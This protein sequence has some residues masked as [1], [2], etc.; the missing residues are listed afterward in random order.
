MSH[1]SVLLLALLL[2]ALAACSEEP[3]PASHPAAQAQPAAASTPIATPVASTS[4]A[5]GESGSCPWLSSDLA[6]GILGADVTVTK[7]AGDPAN[8]YIASTPSTWAGEADRM[9]GYTLDSLATAFGLTLEPVGGLG[10]RAGW[11]SA[12]QWEGND[13]GGQ[14]LVEHGGGV[15]VVLLNATPPRPGLREKAEAL[16]RAIVATYPA[17]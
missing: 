17:R 15:T 7:P 4:A 6:T 5:T 1:R 2:P 12:A 8:C 11:K 3:T 16:A 9:E 13:V 14:V 10:E